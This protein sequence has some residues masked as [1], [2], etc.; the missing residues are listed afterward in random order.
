ML[1]KIS[2]VLVRKLR[3]I[4][5]AID[6]LIYLIPSMHKYEEAE[7]ITRLL[8]TGLP[9]A[10]NFDFEQ[11][12]KQTLNYLESVKVEG[13]KYNY[14][15]SQSQEVG[16][17]YSSVYALLILDLYGELKNLS[18]DE[19]SQWVVYL[20]SF[21]EETDGLWHDDRLLNEHYADSDWWGARHLGI[22]MI[23]AYTALGK[24]PKY[25]IKYITKY[26]DLGYMK[27]WLDR[28]DWDG[29]FENENDVDN[30]IMNIGVALQYQRDYFDD[31]KAKLA[32]EYLFNYLDSKKN[33]KTGMWGGCDVSDPKQ[34]SRSIQ[35][36][37]HL[38][39]LYFYDNRRI[40]C[41]EEILEYALQTQNRLGGFGVNLNSSAC[42]DI[43]SIEL[44]LHL[45]DDENINARKALSRAFVWILSN[46]MNDGGFVFRQNQG[47]WYG[48]ESLTAN[49]NESHL[50]ATWF[51]TL[52]LVKLSVNL[53]PTSKYKAHDAPGY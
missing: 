27:S 3:R 47:M 7:L 16:N 23:A 29:Y 30:Q 1:L 22:H 26:Y 15:F 20:D 14:K 18:A 35:F 19:V 46:Q 9:N 50:F 44:I 48:H 39:M 51:R 28:N 4:I 38:L 45:S 41:G 17:L 42:E 52:S 32:L 10:M 21:Q 2:K 8:E 31:K 33:K 43:D 37:Y 12:K 13:K 34:L 40:E 24:K 36:A 53:F 5:T 11:L 6:K 49:I 25:Q